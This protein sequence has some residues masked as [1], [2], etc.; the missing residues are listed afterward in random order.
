[1]PFDLIVLA[2]KPTNDM[3]R[4][5]LFDVLFHY[6]DTPEPLVGGLSGTVLDTGLGWGKYDLVLTVRPVAD[7]LSVSLVY[8]RD[9]FDDATG[10]LLARRFVRLLES[11]T[12]TPAAPLAS[13]DIMVEGELE[14]LIERARTLA[15]YPRERTIHGIFEEVAARRGDAVAI[16]CDGW[17]LSYADVNRLANRLAHRLRALGVRPDDR[18]GVYMERTADLPVAFLGILKA[19]GAYVP[20]D[21]A[22]PSDRSRFMAEDAGLSVVV[23]DAAN[24]AAAAGLGGSTTRIVTVR[25]DDLPADTGSD[26]ESDPAPAAGPEN[27]AYIIFTSGSTG[28]PKGT[29]IEHRNVV[30]LMFHE[31]LPF[32]FGEDDAWTLFHSPCFDFSVWEMYGALLYGGRLVI[33]PRVVAQDAGAYVDLLSRERI[34]VLNQ[35]PTAFYNLAEAALA[36]AGLRLSLREVVFGGEALLPARLGE[37]HR[38]YPGIRLV[39]MYGITETTVHVTWKVIGSAEIAD[40]RSVIGGPLA[41]YGIV[42]MDADLRLMPVGV[43]GEICVTGHGVTRGY[44]NR[45]ELTAERFIEHADLSGVRLYR[46]GDLGRLTPDGGLVYLGRLDDQVKIRGFRIELGEIERQLLNLPGIQAAVVLPDEG[47]ENLTAYLVAGG[48][49]GEAGL[50]REAVYRHLADKLPDYMVPSRLIQVPAIPTTANGK[51]DRR[52]LVESGG[53]QLAAAASSDAATADALTPLQEAIAGIWRGVLDIDTVR[54]ADNFFELGGHS[55]KANQAVARIRQNL[56]KQIS[57]KDFFSS[58]TLERLADLIASREAATG[59]AI[60]PVLPLADPSDGHPLSFAQRRLWLLQT[61]QPDQVNYNMVGAF[62]LE[63]EVSADALAGAFARL[64][65]RHEI[66]RTRFVARRGEARQV[67]DPAAPPP[68]VLEHGLDVETALG[69]EFAH[70]FDLTAGPLLR[71]RLIRLP[72]DAPQYAPRH[73]LVLNL[74]HIIADGW[75]VTVMLRDLEALYR[76]ELTTGA[77]P[78]P[79]SIQYKDFAAWQLNRAAGSELEPARRHWLLLFD[80]G[81]PV[82]EL[83]TDRPRPAV[84]SGRG[85]IVH[86]TLGEEV[87]AA[88]RVLARN[89]GATLFMVLSALVQV[90][91]HLLSGQDDIVLGTPVAGRQTVELERQIGFYLNLLPLRTRLG[92]D[93]SFQGL[94][95]T[96][97]S[98]VL[99]AFTHE[100]FPFDRLVEE[101]EPPRQDGR[102][103]LFDVLLIL[104][105]NEPVRLDLPGVATTILRDA[106]ISAKYDLNYMV[107]DKPALELLLEYS[108]DLFNEATAQRIADAFAELAEAVAADP[109]IA[110][111]GLHTRF[112]PTPPAAV[113]A[114]LTDAGGGEDLLMEGW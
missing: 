109:G 77:V 20:I 23:T 7:G 113:M 76:A 26:Q 87:S 32:Q 106:S 66:L 63:G 24:A 82:L 68:L 96:V 5:A 45:P 99:D 73:A 52:R 14:H 86:A 70:V 69:E 4:T 37:W 34:T 57:L 58:P 50:S 22:Y 85:G 78:P 31:G 3:S 61:R 103:P 19:G 83:P 81:I 107:E 18:V 41:S 35:T 75:S 71:A 36:R 48:P 21:V 17:T 46:S 111:A 43:P 89:H 47:A 114:H 25:I 59:G 64:V 110:V 101:L 54:A 93:V 102:H 80:E 30:Q 55:L 95:S 49:M 60:T 108:A 84:P 98:T 62:I 97:R 91:L 56:G 15:D 112:A 13:L 9:I 51:I 2:V 92:G 44:L 38:R 11:A 94:L 42:L 72:G 33:V 6:D 10:D 16:S 105:N 100:A 53:D 90:Q 74:H 88:L 1:M 65:E 39:N 29:M 79:L 40:G 104:Q 8:N 12:A 28:R 27:L 67:I